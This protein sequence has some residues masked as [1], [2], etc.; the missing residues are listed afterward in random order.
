MSPSDSPASSPGSD[1]PGVP[2]G[3]E[4][5]PLVLRG[6][7]RRHRLRIVAVGAVGLAAVVVAAGVL[8]TFSHAI[9]FRQVGIGPI[10]LLP[11]A[12]VAHAHFKQYT[13]PTPN[14]YPT[15]LIVGPDGALYFLEA[16]TGAIVRFTP[17]GAVFGTLEPR[18][19]FDGLVAGPDGA[20]WL[21][22]PDANAIG[23]LSLQGAFS[24]YPIPE[25][26][27]VPDQIT[28]GPDGALWFTEVET[29]GRISTSG[30]L[31][32]F[33]MGTGSD[34]TS[35]VSGHG[36]IWVSDDARGLITRLTPSGTQTAFAVPRGAHPEAMTAGPDGAL[37][38]LDVSQSEIGRM[39]TS[40]SA[41]EFSIPT[42]ASG[43]TSIC[44]GPD[45]NV[46]F[47]ELNSDNVGR[48]TPD[49]LVTEFKAPDG[50]NPTG[51]VAGPDGNIW[52]TEPGTNQLGEIILHPHS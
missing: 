20:L 47:T 21:T 38:W 28:V 5:G 44:A 31:T 10:K 32:E 30:T 26:D 27:K 52:F 1:G 9:V 12:A 42:N 37:W 49:G 8:I 43:L 40:G 23:R 36:A 13:L 4:R 51:I 11:V 39:T 50:S 6:K 45:G 34:T 46:W 3:G 41:R 48:L 33:P 2:A 25:I 17:D 7:R 24:E 35:I 14:A 18:R 15:S 22:E 19:H 29:I 16:G